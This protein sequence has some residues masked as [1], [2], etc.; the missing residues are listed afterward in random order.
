MRRAQYCF[1]FDW[2]NSAVDGTTAVQSTLRSKATGCVA[3][4]ANFHALV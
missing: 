3:K 2:S 1:E 4:L